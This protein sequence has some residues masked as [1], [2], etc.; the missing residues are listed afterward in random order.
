MDNTSILYRSDVCPACRWDPLLSPGTLTR[1][2]VKPPE[3]SL[4]ERYRGTPYGLALEPDVF[5]VDTQARA[6][7]SKGR[8]VVIAGLVVSIGIYGT[9][10]AALGGF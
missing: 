7:I 5:G 8:V 2:N 1:R 10:L 6:G 3:M 4:S 9:V